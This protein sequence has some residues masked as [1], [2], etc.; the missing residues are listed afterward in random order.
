MNLPWSMWI[1]CGKFKCCDE[2]EFA[3]MNLKLPW[4]LWICRGE[5]EFAVANLNWPWWIRNCRS[6]FELS[7]RW[8]KSPP[9]LRREA[10]KKRGVKWDLKMCFTII[11]HL[12]IFICRWRDP[13]SRVQADQVLFRSCI[14]SKHWFTSIIWP[15]KFWFYVNLSNVICLFMAMDTDR[16]FCNLIG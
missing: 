14:S 3:V 12:D 1:C 4:W 10:V 6:E 8:P 2:F 7:E 9:F 13:N 15:G 16:L 11:W 5:F